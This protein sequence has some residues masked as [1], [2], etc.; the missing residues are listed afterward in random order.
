MLAL[1]YVGLMALTVWIGGLLV[2]GGIGA[3]AIFGVLDTRHVADG[4][5]LAG[6]IFG[7]AFRRFTLASYVCGALVLGTLLARAV[8]GPRP[9]RFALR[10]GTATA[11][12]AASAYSGL[13]VTPAIVRQQAEIEAALASHRAAD[14]YREAF[15]RL[16]ARSTGVQLIPILGGLMLLFWE[17]KE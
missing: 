4:R 1:R 17:V 8:L 6:A 11:M 16:H 10:L 15:G 9:M 7:E 14:S 12:V 5:T 13:I 2:L 3:P